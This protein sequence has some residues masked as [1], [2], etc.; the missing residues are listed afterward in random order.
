MK[1]P[2]SY[3]GGKQTML[4]H[5]MPLLPPHKIYTEPF[6]GGASVFF[7]KDPSAI[8]VIND[9][10]Q[11]LINFYKV[12]KCDFK[13]LKYKIDTTLHSRACF[14]FAAWVYD[15]PLYFDSIDRA[16]AVWVLSKISFASKLDGSFGYDRDENCIC[17][18]VGNAKI[19]F[20]EELS[21]RLENTQIECTSAFHIIQSRD[22]EQAFHFVDPPYIGTDC[23]HYSDTFSLADFERLLELLSGLNGK[24]M[25][26]M[27]PHQVLAERI[28]SQGW[29]VIEVE[30]T[31][32]ASK[33]KRRKQIELI[34]MNY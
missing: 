32:S 17:K 3:Y 24:F 26:T 10:N 18:K 16:W 14:E 29:R 1:T 34:V 25:L 22:C 7:A 5:I 4:K 19:S 28:K 31:I 23:G 21:R 15:H 8:E 6:A 20:T 9:I 13:A 12:L 2:I 27:F 30:R 11:N 33:T